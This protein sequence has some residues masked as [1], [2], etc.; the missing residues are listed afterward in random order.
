ML[1]TWVTFA[2]CFL[3]IFL[4]APYVE[5]LRGNRPL[6]GA[7]AAISAAVVGVILNLALW[8]AI[9]A[10]FARVATVA[11][12]PARFDVPVVASVDP[13]ALALSAAALVAVLRFNAGVLPTLGVASV[14][15]IALRLTGLH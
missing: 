15:G 1:A 7:L 9:H 2:P 11:V 8:F 10:V 13:W 12:G 6:S 4:G 3:W 5:R 14:A